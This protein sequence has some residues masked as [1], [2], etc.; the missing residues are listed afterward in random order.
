MQG[1]LLED[2]S[3]SGTTAGPD[4]LPQPLGPPAPAGQR[5]GAQRKSRELLTPP[6][7]R[8]CGSASVLEEDWGV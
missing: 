3:R 7:H 6:S 1:G 2:G 8:R 4:A 5:D